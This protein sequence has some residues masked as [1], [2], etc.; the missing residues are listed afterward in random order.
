MENKK[1]AS[2]A[3]KEAISRLEIRQAEEGRLLKEHLIVVYEKLKPFN[4]IR[5]AFDDIGSAMENR[6]GLVNSLVGVLT[7]YITQKLIIGSKAGLIKKLSGVL[8]NYG[9]AALVSKYAETFKVMGLQLFNQLFGQKSI[10]DVEPAP[11]IKK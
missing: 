8:L 11:E 5:S 10:E 6:K 1:D 7:G 4:L 2:A 3:L 9:V